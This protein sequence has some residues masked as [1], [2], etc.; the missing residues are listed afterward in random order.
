MIKVFQSPLALNELL[1]R[2]FDLPLQLTQAILSSS[3]IP[4]H[5]LKGTSNER[6]LKKVRQ[7]CLH[8]KAIVTADSPPKALE[9]YN[10]GAD[11]V[12]IPR[13]HSSA[14]IAEVIESGRRAALDNIC[15]DEIER[16]QVRDEVIA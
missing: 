4:D 7:L 12:F 8:A 3:T 16:L 11:F 6:L 10:I 2:T 13:L 5:I 15:P 1:C 9:L 14:Q